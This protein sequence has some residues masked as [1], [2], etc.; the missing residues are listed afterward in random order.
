MPS[1]FQQHLEQEF[2]FA[3]RAVQGISGGDINEARLLRTDR[4]DFF[5]KFNQHPSAGDMLTKEAVGLRALDATNTLRVPAVEGV[6]TVGDYAYLLLEYLPTERPGEH[7]WEHFGRGLAQLHGQTQQSW[8]GW[9]GANFIG[10]LPQSNEAH[11]NWADF[12][13][14]ERLLPQFRLAQDA[15]WLNAADGQQLD[16]LVRELPR[17][18][19]TEPASLVHGDLWSGNFLAVHGEEPA[20]ID[21]SVAYA[22]REL[23]LAMTQLFGGFPRDFYYHYEEVYPLAAGFEQ[24]VGLYQLY[25]LLVHVNLFGSSYVEAVRRVLRLYS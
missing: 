9:E 13:A 12:Y 25:Y 4:G 20:L 23:D 15:G 21:P 6:G 17:S 3:I 19:P 18:C 10:S 2:H 22:H 5:M 1:Q 11:T 8:F 14:A 24:R 16:T 7:F